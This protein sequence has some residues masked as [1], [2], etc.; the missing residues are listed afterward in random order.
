MVVVWLPKMPGGARQQRMNEV[1][2]EMART[3]VACANSTTVN[4]MRVQ[5]IRW[6]QRLEPGAP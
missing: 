6:Q 1:L 5:W 2:Q 4:A 3:L